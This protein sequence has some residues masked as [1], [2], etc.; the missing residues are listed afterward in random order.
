M[1]DSGMSGRVRVL[2]AWR[3]TASDEEARAFLQQRLGIFSG[4]LFTGLGL[5]NTF[6]ALLYS[7]VPEIAPEHWLVII[8]GAAVAL[9]VLGLIWRLVLAR[10]RLSER[11]LYRYD[12]AYAIATG[13]WMGVAAV[14]SP[15]RRASGYAV[16]VQ[17]I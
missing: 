8:G 14:L 13:L 2:P 4:V 16:L 3:A 5:L 1:S 9:V 6:F 11:R 12:A 15:E 10:R 17:T 7:Q